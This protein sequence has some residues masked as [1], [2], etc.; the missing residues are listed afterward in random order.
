MPFLQNDAVQMLPYWLGVVPFVW[1]VAKGAA[2]ANRIENVVPIFGAMSA[3]AVAL[4]MGI[5]YLALV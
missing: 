3:I 1:F 4:A 5:R 2:A